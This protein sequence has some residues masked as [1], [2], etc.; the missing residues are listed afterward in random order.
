MVAVIHK[1]KRKLNF[2]SPLS[3][4]TGQRSK[5]RPEIKITAKERGPGQGQTTFWEWHAGAHLWEIES[6]PPLPSSTSAGGYTGS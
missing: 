5:W 3:P 4:P 6:K 2:F 1:D